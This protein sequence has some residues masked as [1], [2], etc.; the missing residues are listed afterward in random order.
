[1]TAHQEVILG[2]QADA[3]H[4]QDSRL[5]ELHAGSYS[6]QEDPEASGLTAGLDALL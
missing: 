2:A 5:H 1:M 4:S 3:H 6:L